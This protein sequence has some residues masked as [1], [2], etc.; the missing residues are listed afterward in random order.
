MFKYFVEDELLIFNP[1][2]AYNPQIE[3]HNTP[4]EVFIDMILKIYKGRNPQLLRN[5]LL[6]YANIVEKSKQAQLLKVIKERITPTE[7]K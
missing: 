5:Q 7:I 4:P 6:A 2:L 1:S 3:D